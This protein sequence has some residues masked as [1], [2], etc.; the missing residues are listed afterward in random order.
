MGIE[1][2]IN[3]DKQIDQMDEFFDDLKFKA[4]VKGTRQGLNRAA[5]SIRAKSNKNIRKH[6]KMKLSEI[7]RRIKIRKAQGSILSEL[8]AEVKFSGMPIPMILFL[9]GS[10]TP[11]TQ[12]LPNPRRR[13]RKFEIKQG[14]RKGKPGLFVQKSKRGGLRNQVF[15]REDPNDRTKGFKVQSIPSIAHFLQSKAGM[16]KRLENSAIKIVEQEFV[17]AVN[18]QLSKL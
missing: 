9:I 17:R 1:L 4:I 11:K 18:F 3:L 15:R 8:E 7:K 16:V 5:L 14:N 12:T 6:R 13:T 2:S 10:K